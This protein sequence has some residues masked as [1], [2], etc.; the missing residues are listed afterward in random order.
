MPQNSSAPLEA[1]HVHDELPEGWVTGDASGPVS[2]GPL[3][4]A[5]VAIG[6]PARFRIRA[7]ARIIDTVAL[8]VSAFF[9][10]IVGMI[11]V[12]VMGAMGREI[13]G[14]EQRIEDANM[15]LFFLSLLAMVLHNAVSESLGGASLGK[16]ICGLRVRSEALGSIS[17]ASGLLRNVA[18]LIDS[19]F[20]GLV[21]YGAMSSS[22]RE[23]R[24]G[25]AWSK[26]VVVHARSL[27]PKAGGVGV[28]AL[29]VISGLAMSTA[30]MGAGT[31]LIA[32]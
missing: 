17:M 3:G 29:G 30:I 12:G 19:L 8:Q 9:G 23:Q 24:L 10:A 18:Y 20:F 31:L 25:D 11:V 1:K 27:G 22:E 21:G 15:S 28:T 32:L 16:A 7:L 14:A 4:E 5:E 13:V 6:E 2:G 26:T